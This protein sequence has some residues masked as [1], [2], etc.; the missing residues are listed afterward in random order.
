MTSQ[1]TKKIGNR[2]E[3]KPVNK[4]DT[5]HETW[6][7]MKPFVRFSAKAL[8]VIAH[9]LMFIVKNIPKLDE[10]KPTAAKGSKVIKI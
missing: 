2:P 3:T 5:L 9:S 1:N 6:T 7:T 8:K 4:L 10:H